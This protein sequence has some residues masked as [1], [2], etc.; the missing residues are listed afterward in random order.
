MERKVSGNKDTKISVTVFW[1]S[2]SPLFQP[3]AGAQ[4]GVLNMVFNTPQRLQRLPVSE[5][6]LSEPVVSDVR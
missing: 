2:N 5:Q 4:H 3:T 1:P 6:Q